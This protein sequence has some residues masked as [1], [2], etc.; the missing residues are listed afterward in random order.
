[1]NE[2]KTPAVTKYST[3]ALWLHWLTVPA[4]LLMFLT[5]IQ[6]SPLTP[7]HSILGPI[8]GL[9]LIF[10]M[11]YRIKYGV[12][13]HDTE[14]PDARLQRILIW[15]L[16]ALIPVLLISG[17]LLVW[18]KQLPVQLFGFTVESPWLISE[19]SGKLISAVHYSSSY[20]LLPVIIFHIVV[21]KASERI[22]GTREQNT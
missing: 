20:L 14:S 3:L 21:S 2:H 18:T 6:G 9:F 4:I 19:R 15:G 17:I 5:A 12:R 1:M 22:F 16:L 7:Y 8:I 11:V 10:R 13:L